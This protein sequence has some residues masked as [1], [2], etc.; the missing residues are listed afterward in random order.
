MIGILSSVMRGSGRILPGLLLVGLSATPCLAAELT[1]L[2]AA[3]WDRAPR[4][5]EIDAIF[6]DYL[7]VNDRVALVV[8]DTRPGRKATHWCPS[9]QGAVIDFTLRETN[10][11]QL[12]AFMPHG[13]SKAA[14]ATDS[15]IVVARGRRVV[16]QVTRRAT[17]LNPVEAMT[18]YGLGDGDT[19]LE[20]KTT[21]RNAGQGVARERLSDHVRA[22][23][24]F[25][26]TRQGTADFVYFY[27][28]GFSTAYGLIRRGGQMY[29]DGKGG[30][31][32]LGTSIDFPDLG[33][34]AGDPMTVL[35]PKQQIVLTR[36]LAVGRHPAEVQTLAQRLLG[37][38]VPTSVVSVADERGRAAAGVHLIVRDG[39]T[40]A[41]EATTDERGQAVFSL[42]R[43]R[44]AARA[45]QIGRAPVDT[46]LELGTPK[47]ARLAVPPLSQVSLHVTDTAGKPSP[48]KVQFLGV[49]GTADPQ[50]GP[51]MQASRCRNIYFSGHGSFTTGLPAGKYRVI[52]SR[53][54]EYDSV[55]RDLTLAPGQHARLEARLVRAVDSRG[56]ISAD[57]HSHSS[58]GGDIGVAQ[59][60][61]IL[62]HIGEGIEFAP[63]TEHLRIG[64]YRPQISRLDLG[65]FLATSDGIE[66]SGPGPVDTMHLNA[67]P[68]QLD[69]AQQHY[70][71]PPQVAEPLA[72]IQAVRAFIGKREALV[73]QNHPDIGWLFF[74]K[75]GDGV[76]DSGFGTLAFT[77][78]MEV[79]GGDILSMEPTMGDG[80][81]R[82]KNRIFNWLQILNQGMRIPGTSNTDAHG[83][84]HAGGT[85]RNYIKSSTDDP[86]KVDELEVVRELKK[87][88]VVIG[89]GPFIDASF[90]GAL[91]GDDVEVS[92]HGTLRVRVETANWLDIDRVQV[93]V[94]G[95]P[96]PDLN[97]TRDTHPDAFGPGAVK[98]KRDI[99]VTLGSDAHLIVVAIGE[100]GSTSPIM[101]P[102]GAKPVAMT[103]PI[104]VDVDGKGFTANRDTLGTPLPT[105]LSPAP[106]QFGREKP[107]K[108]TPVRK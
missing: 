58:N 91:P 13:F 25:T 88:H 59:E 96:R 90:E 107:P 32:R 61:R 17:D 39:E 29:T 6:G 46:T 71:A 50:L 27:D 4:G 35:A 67:F 101:G 75:D 11:D 72:Q 5:K 104:Y 28:E 63:S 80:E 105:R 15:Q 62:A 106:G 97:F 54:P 76:P 18:E 93:L 38:R 21:Y 37:H 73:Q 70:G 84:F 81:E 65:K 1:R 83:L 45:S 30:T 98:F 85:V 79:F 10:D 99:P 41:S 78:V 82:I 12:T 56:W 103:N 74:D 24:S 16:L 52:V 69:R 102:R 92:G 8:A 55:E 66:L 14:P 89:N 49:S 94:N 40:W 26:Q 34:K 19:F 48:C 47:R 86:A 9:A 42:P 108:P 95:R 64:S 53:G 20:V 68:L 2:G 31:G 3:N 77:D 57:L 87:G 43:G 7:L 36:Y 33:T 60:A 51:C 23:N 44:Y 22:D 100:K